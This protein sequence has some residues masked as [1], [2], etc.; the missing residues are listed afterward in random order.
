MLNP[1]SC[2]LI[3]DTICSTEKRFDFMISPSSDYYHAQIHLTCGLIYWGPV[4]VAL[5][6]FGTGFNGMSIFADYD[7]DIIKIDRSLINGIQTRP[8]KRFI[9]S[10]ILDLMTALGKDH[11]VEGIESHGQF[12][13][14]KDI[15]FDV[16]QGY[17]FHRPCALEAG[18]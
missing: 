2:C 17:Y 3:A 5:D 6:D 15:G 16:F 13:Q 9:L 11:I 1:A 7:F 8:Q 12:E 4:K 10:H 18:L 14:L